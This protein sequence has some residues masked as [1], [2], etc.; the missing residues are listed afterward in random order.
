MGPNMPILAAATA[1][2]SGFV[3]G[4]LRSGLSSVE[5]GSSASEEPLGPEEADVNRDAIIPDTGL[6]TSAARA[7]S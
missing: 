6:K 5:V 1:G 4:L 3:A 7:N 2:S